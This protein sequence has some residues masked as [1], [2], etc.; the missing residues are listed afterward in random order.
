[1]QDLLD[2]NGCGTSKA[3]SLLRPIL[4]TCRDRMVM[5]VP[6]LVARKLAARVRTAAPAL[7]HAGARPVAAP[8]VAPLEAAWP[9]AAPPVAPLEAAWP[10]AAPPPVLPAPSRQVPVAIEARPQLETAL[11]VVPRDES[12]RGFEPRILPEPIVAGP[13]IMPSMEAWPTIMIA[14]HAIPLPPEFVLPRQVEVDSGRAWTRA[15]D[16]QLRSQWGRKSLPEIV[17]GLNQLEDPCG[18]TEVQ[19]RWR[20]IG[21]HRDNEWSRPRP[22]PPTR[23][24]REAPDPGASG[25]GA[26]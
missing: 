20:E 3:D 12:P 25:P 8:P 9:V 16:Y 1:V 17:A 21:L 11:K 18:P 6:L 4:A 22:P 19:R 2:E 7:P 15:E 13:S 5:K 26:A 23:V 24:K 10:I 14:G